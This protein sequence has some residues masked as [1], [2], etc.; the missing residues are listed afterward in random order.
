MSKHGDDVVVIFF[1]IP[2]YSLTHTY[3]PLECVSF[4][5]DA[6]GHLF[7]FFFVIFLVA[8][9][10]APDVLEGIENVTIV[11]DGVG[12]FGV[13]VLPNDWSFFFFRFFV[14]GGM[15]D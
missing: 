2:C 8:L 5:A 15:M 1:G 12:G 7:I 3:L 9:G 4:K 13:G 10:R 11:R 14:W 6:A